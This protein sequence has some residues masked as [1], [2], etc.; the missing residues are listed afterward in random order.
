M[1]RQHLVAVLAAV[2]FA[3]P[4]IL[5]SQARAWEPETT[6]AGLAEQAALASRL[7]KRLVTLGFAGGLFEPLTIPPADAPQ[8]IAALKLLSPTHGAVPDARGRQ[9]ALGWLAAGAALADV[10]A[11]HGA[12][13]FFD[14]STGRGWSEPDRGVIAGLTDKV[15]EAIGRASLPEHGVPAPDWV[16]HKDN[17][18]NLENFLSQYTKAVTAST[19]GERSRHMAAALVAA[20]A[21]LHTLGDLGVPS[22]VRSDEA[23]HLEPLGGGPDD[24]GS[25]F[26]RIAAL[27]YGR[28]GV[29]APSRVVTRTRLR[30]F[31]SSRDGQGL[32]DQ[33]S[34][35]YFSS[36]TLPKHSRVGDDSKPALRR[37]APTLPARLNLMAASRDEGTLLRNAAGV[38]LARYRVDH[39]VLGFSFD[40]E[41]ALEQVTAILPEVAAY[42]TG[43]LEYLIRG[44]LAIAVTGEIVVTGS[45]LGA[46]TVEMLV[47]DTR[48]V[49]TRLSATATTAGTAELARGP[50]PTAGTRIVAVFRGVDAAGEPI[51]AVGAMPLGR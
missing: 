28:L 12:N 22:R 8:L 38:C 14:P 39:G 26:E 17:P 34:R 5:P 51:V 21:I 3:V 7:H 47:E 1:S 23:A 27:A 40:D 4:A 43:L 46:G 2:A 30:D 19:P 18:F 44:E 9:V 41:C 15:R 42:E 50:T 37:P 33:I 32:A 10:P 45:G 24:L 6:H 29:P 31:F 36:N 13:H 48:G 16:T 25:R 20:G 35:S 11:R 49:R